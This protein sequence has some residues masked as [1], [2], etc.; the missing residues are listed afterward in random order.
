MSPSLTFAVVSDT[1]DDVEGI[2]AV[3]ADIARRG[4]G[5]DAIL[6]P[7]DLTS[8][9]NAIG[10]S[11]EPDTASRCRALAEEVCSTNWCHPVQSSNVHTIW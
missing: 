4:V 3:G 1:H 10:S 7:G 6:C 11:L 9:P 8:A 2:R 5:V